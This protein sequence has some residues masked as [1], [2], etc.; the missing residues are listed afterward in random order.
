M[1]DKEDKE[2]REKEEFIA[3]ERDSDTKRRADGVAHKDE[4]DATGKGRLAKF[5]GKLVRIRQ[6]IR[7]YKQKREVSAYKKEVDKERQKENARD[8]GE[9]KV[10][11][12]TLSEE[13]RA[14]M[15]RRKEERAAK[16]KERREK[17]KQSFK[18]AGAAV[19]TIREKISDLPDPAAVLGDAA[20]QFSNPFDLTPQ[21]PAAPGK[22]KVKLGGGNAPPAPQSDPLLDMFK[23]T[24]SSVLDQPMSGPDLGSFFKI[25]GAPQP[26]PVPGKPPKK[27]KQAPPPKRDPLEEMFGL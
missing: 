26:E 10:Y 25:G 3:K 24:P 16:K 17:I 6:D 23:I 2:K 1:E 18:S 4:A 20:P 7:V 12:K 14:D 9:I 21:S 13:E 8:A 5:K 22:E 11:G 27:G 15:Q 19:G